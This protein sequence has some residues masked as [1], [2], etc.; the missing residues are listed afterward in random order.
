MTGTTPNDTEHSLR[1]ALIEAQY[2][3]KNSASASN[4]R[5]VLVLVSGIELAGKGEA[6]TQLREWAD[7]RLLKVSA[8]LPQQQDWQRPFWQ[9][10]IAD[11]PER[12][13]LRVLFGNW[14]GDLL[15]ARLA[16]KKQGISAEEFQQQLHDIQAFEEYLRQE[17]VTLVKC[18]FDL[19]WK[20]LQ[21]RLNEI[22]PSLLKW[23]KLHGLDWRDRDEY[24]KLQALRAQLGTDWVTIDG[25][26]AGACHLAFAQQI[27]LAL[28][29]P[30][31]PRQVP[32]QR[33]QP[34][35]I[36]P[37]LQTPDRE[38][39]KKEAYKQQRK[40]LQAELTQL[41]RQRGDRP[42]I[43]VFEGMDAAGKGGAIRRVVAQ[44]DPRE[45]QIHCIAA[46]EAYEQ[47][48]PYLW[49]FWRRLPERAGMA[50]FDRSWYGRVLVERVEQLVSPVDWQRAYTEINH[51]ERNLT[52]AGAIVVKFW[53]SIDS[54]EQLLRFQARKDT[55]HKR[56][57]LT[58]DD[59]RNRERWDEYVQ[60]AADLLA[61][62]DQPHAPWVV[63]ATNDKYSA[64]LAVLQG[65]IEHLKQVLEVKT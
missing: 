9:P 16:G 42:V 61:R 22:E 60:A 46:P 52:D 28:N 5:S 37:V 21:Q 43:V 48:H 11:I 19:S 64:R 10:Y 18:W 3:L 31:L 63:V 25:E 47:R 8:H 36:P 23:Q 40:Q 65:L 59:W 55:P 20:T 50:I 13:E 34:S 53:L 57:K 58:D 45:Y 1:L 35:V 30:R 56:F 33:W 2:A 26:D 29:A 15:A 39:L 49:R 12:G 51:F 6:V 24:D 17:G 32:R 44:L 4:G 54:D 7:P 27:L 62:T 41:L 38:I 14:H